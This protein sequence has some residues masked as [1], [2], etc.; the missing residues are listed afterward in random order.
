MSGNCQTIQQNLCVYEGDDV[1]LTFTSDLGDLTGYAIHF[2]A[3]IEKSSRYAIIDE[4]GQVTDT[5]GGYSITFPSADTLGKA[6][7]NAFYYDVKLTSPDGKIHT[8]RYGMFDIEERTTDIQNPTI[9]SQGVDISK[10]GAEVKGSADEISFNG[11]NLDV[12]TVGNGV[13]V[14]VDGVR[15]PDTATA[16][17]LYTYDPVTEKMV[18]TGVTASN[19]SVQASSGSVYIGDHSIHSVGQNVG[20]KNGNSGYSFVPPWQQI[21]ETGNEGPVRVS[22][23]TGMQSVVRNADVSTDLTNPTWMVEGQTDDEVLFRIKI[24]DVVQPITNVY[25]YGYQSGT[26]FFKTKLGDLVAGENTVSLDYPVFIKQV[27]SISV[28]LKSDDGDVIVK[29]AAPGIPAYTS[30]FRLYEERE[31]FDKPPTPTLSLHFAGIYNDLQSLKDAIPVP[32]SNIQAIVLSPSEKYYHGVGN[33]WVELAPVSAFH[34]EYLGAYDTVQDLQIAEPTPADGSLAII[35]TVS[36]SFYFYGNSAW[37]KVIDTDL[38]GLTSKVESNTQQISTHTNQISTLGSEVANLQNTKFTGMHVEDSAGNAFDDIDSLDFGDSAEVSNPGG[39]V[40]LITVKPKITVANGQAPGS[41]SV[42]GNA[43]VIEG[44]TVSSDVNDPDVIKVTAFG[45]PVPFSFDP[46]KFK[47]ATDHG[48]AADDQ[49][50]KSQK[51]TDGWW[52][53]KDLPSVGGR[54]ARS[55]GDLIVFKN[56]VD[57]SE[58]DRAHVFVMAIGTDDDGR[59]EIWFMYRNK[60]SWTPWIDIGEENQV[61]INAV[62]NDVTNLK[63]GVQS[64]VDKVTALE[65]KLGQAYTPSKK[66]F[67]DEVNALIAAALKDYIPKDPSHGGSKV[68]VEYPRIYAQFSNSIPTI[69]GATTSTTSKLT[70][71]RASTAVSRIFVL[72]ENDNNE[73]SRVTGISVNDALPASWDHRDATIDG[74]KYRAFFSSGAYAESSVTITVNFKD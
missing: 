72:V 23:K 57:S 51:T 60:D 18:D 43:I 14:E 4:L 71:T 26:E 31:L 62:A 28:Q 13:S 68:S 34:P 30:Y 36:K 19:G 5:S 56:D 65:T 22:F 35:G 1:T 33:S 61:K 3:R 40:A 16:N 37:T 74:K 29:G 11:K 49:N 38:P 53:F 39:A 44:A 66:A 50:I 64:A 7:G 63:A 58:P 52:I 9:V 59:S 55:K 12:K 48:Y 25:L 45:S 73:A 47:S 41:T 46:D 17:A 6:G 69:T 27:E 2:Q 21:L 24:T 20:V 15:K 8:D 67:D 32:T 54:P 10:D 42:T 70:L